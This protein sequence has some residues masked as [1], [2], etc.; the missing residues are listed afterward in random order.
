MNMRWVRGSRV[1]AGE[2]C[3]GVEGSRERLQH[4]L[5][6]MCRERQHR[7]V[8]TRSLGSG[9]AGSVQGVCRGDVCWGVMGRAGSSSTGVC[10]VVMGRAGSSSTGVLGLGA[11]VGVRERCRLFVLG[12][13]AGGRPAA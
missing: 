8:Y 7:C 10:W 5:D 2:A 9:A 1:L 13:G 6:L 3:A 11:A 12:L 4:D